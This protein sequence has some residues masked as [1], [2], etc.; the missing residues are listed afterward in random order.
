[1]TVTLFCCLLIYINN[2]YFYTQKKCVTVISLLDFRETLYRQNVFEKKNKNCTFGTDE[3][4]RTVNFL[5][6]SL[7]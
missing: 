6:P 4:H 2:N 3:Y 5:G 7:Q 1:M